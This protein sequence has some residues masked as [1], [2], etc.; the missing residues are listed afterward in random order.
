MRHVLALADA[1]QGP[2]L[3]RPIRPAIVGGAAVLLV[4]GCGALG[5]GSTGVTAPSGTT[6]I[7]IPIRPISP[8]NPSS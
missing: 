7:C 3:L 4:A 8:R 1:L 5:G 2:R 6:I